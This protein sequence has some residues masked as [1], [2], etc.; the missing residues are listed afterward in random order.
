MPGRA[1]S[2]RGRRLPR[3]SPEP[4]RRSSRSHIGCWCVHRRLHPG[5]PRGGPAPRQELQPLP[6]LAQ[7]HVTDPSG[8]TPKR[9]AHQPILHLLDGTWPATHAHPQP[10]RFHGQ[11]AHVGRLQPLVEGGLGRGARLTRSAAHELADL[12]RLGL[13]VGGLAVRA[14]DE[15]GLLVDTVLLVELDRAHV[16]EKEQKL[17]HT[18]T[19]RLEQPTHRVR[20]IRLLAQIGA[21]CGLGGAQREAEEGAFEARRHVTTEHEVGLELVGELLQVV[22]ACKANLEPRVLRRGA[23]EEARV[24][25]KEDDVL[26]TDDRRHVGE[27]V[28]GIEAEAEAAGRDA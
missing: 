14:E 26:A 23:G 2:H 21:R 28:R 8:A 9:A 20:G 5:K 6:L 22:G 1:W 27:V 15:L 11:L 16:L 19:Q 3:L 17:G 7:A 18:A 24:R 12:G 10:V 25:I 13:A 4:L